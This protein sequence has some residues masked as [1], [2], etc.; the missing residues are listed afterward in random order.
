M[1]YLFSSYHLFSCFRSYEA[2]IAYLDVKSEESSSASEEVLRGSKKRALWCL[3]KKSERKPCCV[4]CN[5]CTST[6]H[7]MMANNA[8]GSRWL[9]S[10]GRF[11]SIGAAVISCRNERAPDGLVADAHLSDG[12]LHLILVKDC[13]HA[14]YLW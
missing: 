5:V 7:P 6:S 3:P 14:L 13:P 1:F 9:K 8:E 12:F 2:E 11:L 10:K 4:D